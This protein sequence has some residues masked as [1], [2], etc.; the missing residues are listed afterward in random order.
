MKSLMY[1]DWYRIEIPAAAMGADSSCTRAPEVSI[2][3][4]GL[5]EL[6]LG[7]GVE[8]TSGDPART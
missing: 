6:S 5:V 1:D 2:R 7:S 3:T 8:R 4:N